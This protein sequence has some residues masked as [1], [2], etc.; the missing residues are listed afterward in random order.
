MTLRRAALAWTLATL[1]WGLQAAQTVGEEPLP[2]FEVASIRKSAGDISGRPNSSTILTRLPGRLVITNM[3]ARGIIRNAY[4]VAI[5][6]R[7]D[8]VGG[9]GWIDNDRWDV[10]ATLATEE[11]EARKLLMLRRLLAERFRLV[12]SRQTRR[13]ETYALVL[14][15]RD[16]NLAPG[17]RRSSPCTRPPGA[18]PPPDGERPCGGRGGAGRIVGTGMTMDRLAMLLESRAG[19]PVQNQTGLTGE[20]DVDISWSQELSVFTAIREQLGLTLERGTDIVRDSIVIDRIER[21]SAN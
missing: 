15:R 17:L 8:V 13:V 6:Q 20:F 2:A 18:S 4:G 7:D 1:G 10:E 12:V 11:S 14:D 3:T 9:P 5:P 19:R 21:P 16:G